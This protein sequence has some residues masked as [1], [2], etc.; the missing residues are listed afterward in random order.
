[1]KSIA[2]EK[3]LQKQSWKDLVSVSKGPHTESGFHYHI[4]VKLLNNKKGATF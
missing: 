2:I 1:M 4:C 3:G